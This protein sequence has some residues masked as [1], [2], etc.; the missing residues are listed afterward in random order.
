MLGPLL[1]PD[2]HVFWK[3]KSPSNC[4]SHLSSLD[5][6]AFKDQVIFVYMSA[7]NI[8]LATPQLFRV[9]SVLVLVRNMTCGLLK[10]SAVF[11]FSLLWGLSFGRF[12]WG[13]CLLILGFT[14]LFFFPLSFLHNI[15]P[16]R[17]PRRR[18]KGRSLRRL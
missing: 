3:K 15:L 16:L 11:A 7:L 17:E 4:I 13:Q 9:V 12:R 8:E 5:L 14:S 2:F 18:G 10:S 6:F 1:L